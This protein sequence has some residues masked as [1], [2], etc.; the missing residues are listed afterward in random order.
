MNE[1]GNMLKNDEE[2]LV[3]FVFFILIKKKVL[4][5]YFL[6]QLCDYFLTQPRIISFLLSK[7]T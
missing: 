1:V 6:T 7:G 4:C 2:F 3:M 5:D